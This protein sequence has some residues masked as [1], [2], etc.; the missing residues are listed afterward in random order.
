MKHLITFENFQCN[1][2]LDFI[3]DRITGS[4]F[5][6]HLEF[7]NESSKIIIIPND[8]NLEKNK[9]INKELKKNP[10]PMVKLNKI[11]ATRY[12]INSIMKNFSV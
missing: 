6:S 8:V 5:I 7:Q 11:T 9:I 2:T 3:Y 4:E 12:S 10:L 1:F